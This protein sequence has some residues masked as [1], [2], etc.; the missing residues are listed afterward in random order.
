MESTYQVDQIVWGK[1]N[2]YPWWP[3]FI[4][5]FEETGEFNV[6]FFG[7][8]SRA[9]LNGSKVKRYED[10]KIQK[11][12]QGKSMENALKAIGRIQRGDSSIAEERQRVEEDNRKKQKRVK[13]Q[14][15]KKVKAIE[16]D[17]LSPNLDNSLSGRDRAKYQKFIKHVDKSTPRKKT[18]LKRYNSTNN[19]N[20]SPKETDLAE[21]HILIDDLQSIEE[22][23]N[24]IWLYLR[25]NDFEAKAKLD[26]LKKIVASLMKIEPKTLFSS[27]V[28]S[29]LSKCTNVCRIKITEGNLLYEDIL[30]VFREK[31]KE[32]CDYLIRDG[33]LKENTIFDK[34]VDLSKTGSIQQESNQED[35]LSEQNKS[36][37]E[38]EIEK[39]ETE[40]PKEEEEKEEASLKESPDKKSLKTV[41]EKEKEKVK[42]VEINDKIAFRVKR[43]FA[44]SIYQ[45]CGRKDLRRR[46]CENIATALETAIRTDSQ[47][48]QEYKGWVIR[49][50]KA[51]EKDSSFLSSFLSSPPNKIELK[52]MKKIINNL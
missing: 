52:T 46:S 7:D 37:I 10:H 8:F 45:N 23:L 12:K 14:K 44:K 9:I 31:T 21:S 35:I 38:K 47:G 17:S 41:E 1:V 13:K 16:V 30:E 2:G 40:K 24:D 19:K 32:I 43:K 28:G 51:I 29:L 5:G 36:E 20:T 15:I 42:K 34:F 50:V 25:S 11:D 18:R 26:E 49:V 6:M 27:G 48:L 33:F 39:I 4:K 22:S 3:G